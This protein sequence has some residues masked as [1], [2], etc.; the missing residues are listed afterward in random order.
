MQRYSS[1]L[2]CSIRMASVAQF[3]CFCL[4]FRQFEAWNYDRITWGSYT[5]SPT[6]RRFHEIVNR[7]V[8]FFLTEK[9]LNTPC[10]GRK[11]TCLLDLAISWCWFGWL[12][13]WSKVNKRL[14][15]Y[16]CLMSVLISGFKN[17][18]NDSLHYK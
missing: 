3:Y 6:L 15:N 10:K 14:L 7:V 12:W 17:L 18:I 13:I 4:F 11:K 9:S 16:T 5:Q 1:L 2:V 8:L